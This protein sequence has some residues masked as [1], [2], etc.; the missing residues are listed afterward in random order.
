MAYF[1]ASAHLNIEIPYWRLDNFLIYIPMSAIICDC[2]IKPKWFVL[3][4]LAFIGLSLLDISTEWLTASRHN[5]YA[6][7][8]IVAGALFLYLSAFQVKPAGRSNLIAFLS[9][10]SLGIFA[11]HKYL[12]LIVYLATVKVFA[13]YGIYPERAVA[14]V[15]LSILF[16]CTGFITILA[17]L[18]AVRLM[19]KSIRLRSYLS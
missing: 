4:L 11:I 12:M 3:S 13:I 17:T 16:F 10:Y 1:T 8:S 19:A 9:R 2:A 7:T 18:A 14:G 5:V 15:R 6:R